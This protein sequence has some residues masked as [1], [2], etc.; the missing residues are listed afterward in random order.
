MK[1]NGK[2]RAKERK[3]KK[4]A[5]TPIKSSS[6]PERLISIS[7]PAWQRIL[8]L[9]GYKS[10]RQAAAVTLGKGQGGWGT[11]SCRGCTQQVR[12]SVKVAAHG[13]SWKPDGCAPQRE[14]R[15]CKRK[16]S[17]LCLY[18][19]DCVA[20]WRPDPWDSHTVGRL[21]RRAT[22]RWPN[23]GSGRST[24]KWIYTELVLENAYFRYSFRQRVLSAII[25][26]WFFMMEVFFLFL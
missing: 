21:C 10:I 6:S 23:V 8:V 3:T 16:T 5:L 13:R 2:T 26:L 12:L 7:M 1:K 15:C 25:F 9:I 17:R 22:R 20:L 19:F 24:S 14:T 4:L 11:P 18:H